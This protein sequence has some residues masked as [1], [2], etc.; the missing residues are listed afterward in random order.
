[1]TR[2][3]D[4]EDVS[5]IRVTIAKH[6]EVPL[7]RVDLDAELQDLEA[8]LVSLAQLALAF[9][10]AFEIDIPDE[11]WLELTTVGEMVAYVMDCRGRG[12]KRERPRA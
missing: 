4:V 10:E 6:L 3:V 9:E 12:A 7:E 11:D 1:M 2:S 5:R 8:D